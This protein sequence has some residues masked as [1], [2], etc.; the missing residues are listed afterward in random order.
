[1]PAKLKGRLTWEGW[2]ERDLDS[3][4]TTT[5]NNNKNIKKGNENNYKSNKKENDFIEDR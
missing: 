5:A 2:V 3:G 4:M 1:M